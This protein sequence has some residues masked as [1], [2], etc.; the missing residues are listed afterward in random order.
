MGV[1]VREEPRGSGVW[2]LFINHKGK[3]FAKKVGADK[4][5]ANQIAKEVERQLATGDLGLLKDEPTTPTFAIYAAGYLKKA[6]HT[7]KYSTWKDY[8]GNVRKHLS[9][10]WVRFPSTR[11]LVRGS[12]IWCSTCAPSTGRRPSG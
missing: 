4:R 8:D 7:L 5:V 11:S 6:A 3:R 10:A 9:S 12:R 2:F 1:K